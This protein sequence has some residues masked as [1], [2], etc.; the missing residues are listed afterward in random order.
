MGCRV[1]GSRRGAA[2]AAWNAAVIL[3]RNRCSHSRA[4]PKP[5]FNSRLKHLSGSLAGPGPRQ[6]PQLGLPVTAPQG[7]VAGQRAQG[8]VRGCLSTFSY[9]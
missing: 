4:V 3:S 1:D 9:F 7:L 5:F 8:D 2:S 6:P